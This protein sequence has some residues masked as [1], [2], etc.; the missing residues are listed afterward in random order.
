MFCFGFSGVNLSC[1]LH[2]FPASLK[3]NTGP[4]QPRRLDRVL[5][6]MRST[7]LHLGGAVIIE[8]F[9]PRGSS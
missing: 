1:S 3:F 6:L 8:P 2:L 7:Q 9:H 5:V 4:D